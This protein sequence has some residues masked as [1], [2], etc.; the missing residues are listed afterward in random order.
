MRRVDIRAPQLYRWTCGKGC[1]VTHRQWH[2][3]A[4]GVPSGSEAEVFERD[5]EPVTPI[6]Y[7]G[8]FDIC[9]PPCH[10]ADIGQIEAWLR[11]AKELAGV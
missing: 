5:G 10:S 7:R 6:G 3:V 11:E 2:Y 8:V 1:G 9:L 4:A